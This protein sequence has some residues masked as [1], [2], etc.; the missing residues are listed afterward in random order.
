MPVTLY[1]ATIPTY[2]QILGSVAGLLNKAEDY[3]GERGMAPADLL[4][5][6]LAP[7]MLPFAYQVKSTVAH[8][9]GSVEGVRKGVY[10]PEMTPPPASFPELRQAV[11]AAVG[12]LTAL[13]RQ[14]I[15]GLEGRD[16]RFEM[17]AMQMPFTA[18]GFLLSFSMPN[19]CFHAATAYDI[20]R[21]QGVQLGKRDFLG[22]VRIK[23]QGDGGEA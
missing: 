9:I 14:D 7:D 5:A 10:A 17:G 21:A 12:A 4:Q 23:P 1:D 8:S 6:R 18:E 16:M 15:N 13:S 11:A 20:L 3:C 22:A 19:F 2:L